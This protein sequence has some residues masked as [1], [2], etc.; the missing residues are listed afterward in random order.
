MRRVLAILVCSILTPTAFAQTFPEGRTVDELG[1]LTFVRQGNVTTWSL[2]GVVFPRT[3]KVVT[4]AP[5]GKEITRFK[6]PSLLHSPNALPL[7]SAAPASVQVE[8]PDGNALLFIDGEKVRAWGTSRQFESPALAPGKS[9]P[10]RVRAAYVVGNNFLIEDKE[11]MIRA[12]ESVAV[13]FDGKG[14]LVVP[15]NNKQA[16]R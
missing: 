1:G 11:I 12:G 8:V 5:E 4:R 7:P 14:A 13:T 2:G 6:M 9:Y 3:V 16:Q 10:L 15:L